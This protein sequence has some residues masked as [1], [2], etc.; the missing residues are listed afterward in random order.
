V[1]ALAVIHRL[2]VRRVNKTAQLLTRLVQ[3]RTREL[4]IAEAQARQASFEAQAA[5]RAKSEFLANMS[6]EIRTPMNGV[7][8]M[9]GLL[10]D[11]DLSPEQREYAEIVRGSG[12]AL[13]TVINDILDFSK[14]EAGKL[15]L[16]SFPFDLCT[17]IEEVA[18][19]L[20][21]T[22]QEKDVELISQYPPGTPRD[23]IGDG[24]RIRQVITNLV[25][26]AIKFTPNG[27]VLIA[28]DREPHEQG[29]GRMRVSITDTGIGIPP[30]KIPFLFAKFTQADASTTRRYG[31][32][33]LGLAISKQLVEIMGGSITVESRLG[34]GSRFVFTLPL[35]RGTEGPFSV[36]ASN[37]AGLRVLIVDHN[38]VNRMVLHE[39]ISSWGMRNGSYAEGYQALRALRAALKEGDPFHFAL[40]DHQMQG[41][42][43]AAVAAD[44]RA[45]PALRDTIIVLLT[46]IGDRSDMHMLAVDACLV[47]PVRP[48]YLLSVLT[49][50]WS[51][52]RQAAHP[53]L[54]LTQRQPLDGIDTPKSM[55]SFA[56]SHLRVL[57]AEDNV[58]NQ[59]LAIRLLEKLGLRADVAANGIEVLEMFE[60][61]PYDVIF[62]DCQMPEMNGYD[63]A[64]EIRRRE[65]QDRHVAIIAMTADVTKGSPERCVA[66]GMDDYISKPINMNAIAAA[67]EKARSQSGP[68]AFVTPVHPPK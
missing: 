33:G 67:L 10:L 25:G 35:A 55:D 17:V 27:H 26:N 6:H 42:D 28:V 61:L 24:G 66:A 68:L 11:T 53:E 19:M 7:I 12:E 23:F 4:Q 13:M 48:S 5:N 57:V 37:L 30:E 29:D 45:D 36:P 21:P 47:K 60:L 15:E 50:T 64:T 1:L 51:K 49:E 16:E 2:R 52:R 44:I 63:A 65:A 39:Q 9:A 18:Q 46:R 3:E 58:V 22:A 14:I 31:G 54:P 34:E 8:G 59:K 32:T 41:L 38:N 43:S 20:G 56:N 40:L 62:M